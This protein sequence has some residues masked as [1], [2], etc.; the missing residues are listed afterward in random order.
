[1]RALLVVEIKT[2]FADVQDVLGRLDVKRRLGSTMAA[3]RGWSTSATVPM[4]VFREESTIRRRLAD[5]APLFAHLVMRGRSA[6]AWL[7]HPR[8]PAP[9]GIL[10]CT[11]APRG[12]FRSD[13]SDRRR[14]AG[15]SR[16]PH[17]G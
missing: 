10:L 8:P 14:F 1:L 3:Q 5:H 6:M 9:T 7:R 4:L 12:G 13:V 2:Q 16:E 11:R 15:A 17:H